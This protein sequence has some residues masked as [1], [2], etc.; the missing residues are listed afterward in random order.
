MAAQDM[1]NMVGPLAKERKQEAGDEDT[2]VQ[3]LAGNGMLEVPRRFI[4][5]ETELASFT[6]HSTLSLEPMP[7]IDLEGLHDYRRQFTMAAISS[8]CLHWGCFQVVNHEIPQSILDDALRSAREFFEMTA[9]EKQTYKMELESPNGSGYGIQ[10][11]ESKDKVLDWGDVMFHKNM[12]KWPAK[13]ATYK[14]AMVSYA[15][16]TRKVLETL[17]DVVSVELRLMP[18][19]FRDLFGD[20]EQSLRVNYYPSC[21]QPEL[22]LGLRSHTDPVVFTAL[23]EDQTRG[24]Q[25]K[26]GEKWV[27]VD[28]EP[29]AVVIFVGDQLQIASNGRC[30]AVT[31]RAVVNKDT[32]RISIAMGL[33]PSPKVVVRPA[34]ELLEKGS[35]AR[36]EGR[37]YG[38]FKANLAHGVRW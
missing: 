8:A 27:T 37:T 6:P 21:P 5:S 7:M 13:P 22:V 28:P 15:R 9:K 12:D 26:N 4:R 16:E 10:S 35:P 18:T 31:H 32:D 3:T 19:Y 20:F 38:E 14:S 34:P 29:D 23:L 17:L 11:L 25:V 30:K 33:A 2:S 24:L 36:Y 1:S